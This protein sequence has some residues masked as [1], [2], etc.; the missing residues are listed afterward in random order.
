[1]SGRVIE[2]SG[3]TAQVELGEG[4]RA[5]CRI[6]APS[7]ETAATTKPA[8]ALPDLASLTSM[9]Q[10]RWKSGPAADLS[11]PQELRAGQVASFRIT[12]LDRA[13]KKI[14]VEPVSR[15]N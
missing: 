1:M 13:A 6:S 8:Q 7:R 12:N 15:G 9:L 14:E 10:A 11:N 4:I 2:V 5:N 3:S